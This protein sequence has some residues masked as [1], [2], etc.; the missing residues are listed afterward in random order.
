MTDGLASGLPPDVSDA[1]SNPGTDHLAPQLAAQ[2]PL[3]AAW[4]SPDGAAFDFDSRM[5]GM[6][7]AQCGVLIETYRR[8]F[9]VAGQ[10]STAATLVESLEAWEAE[11]GLPDRCL[12]DGGPR[13]S[14]IERLIEK[15]RDTGTITPAD[16]IALAERLGYTITIEEPTAFEVGISDCGG[17]DELSGDP[18]TA[19]EFDWIV[20]VHGTAIYE[21]EA[22]ISET[23]VD[24]LLDFEEATGLVCLFRDRAPAWTRVI[25]AYDI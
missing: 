12:G 23:G 2:L 10:E 1:E 14:R 11:F 13:A 21:F 5:G 9:Q 19:V 15:I 20:T 7:R 22:G 18:D 25:F 17:V 4:R 3:G 8:L 6:I 24:R 16:F